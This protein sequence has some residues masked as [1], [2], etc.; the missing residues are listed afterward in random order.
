MA[1][2]HAQ[3]A[4]LEAGL[5]QHVTAP[6]PWIG[7]MTELRRQLRLHSQSIFWLSELQA[8]TRNEPSLSSS[9]SLTPRVSVILPTWNRAEMIMAAIASVCRQAYPHWELLVIDDGSTDATPEVLA[10]ITDPRVRVIRQEHAGCGVARNRGLAE[11]RGDIIAYIDSDNVWYPTYLEEVV[12]AFDAAPDRQ[13]LYLLQLVNNGPEQTTYLRGEPFDR[14]RIRHANWIDLNVFA[15]RRTIAERRG[16]FDPQ[17]HCLI[18]WDFIQRLAQDS[19]PVLIPALGGRYEEGAWKRISNNESQ[20]QAKYQI[21][22]KHEH[23][24]DQPLRVLYLLNSY[25]QI[26]ETYIRTEI[27]YMRR[28]GV[29]VEVCSSFSSLPVAGPAD[30]PVHL[31][32]LPQALI[33]SRPDLVHVHWMCVGLDQLNLIQQAGLPVTYRGHSFEYSTPL[34]ETVLK[35]PAVRRIYLFP[36]MAAHFPA[37]RKIHPLPVAFSPDRFYPPATPKDRRLVVRTGLAKFTKDPLLFLKVAKQCPDHRFV[38]VIATP[39]GL[40]EVPAHIL[41]AK[42]EL[43]SPAEV[44][45]DLSNE[46]AAEVVRS[47]G[48]FLH[49]YSYEEPFGMPISIAEALATGAYVLARQGPDIAGCL[50]PCGALYADA[51]H[52]ARLVTETLS[53]TEDQWQAVALQAVNHAYGHFVDSVVLEAMLDDW[54]VLTAGSTDRGRAA[55]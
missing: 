47:A 17:L 15:H 46:A 32:N 43:N 53:W 23:P 27:E 9:P 13:C 36:H 54:R 11:S 29:H 20:L 55:A 31:G 21:R 51:D 39:R 26:S 10:A 50:G 37:H 4:E 22:R 25:P 6:E 1:H 40:E 42:E 34:A 12:A 3:L 38:L 52:A 16:G 30:V 48:I 14:E 7:P 45:V 44:L 24:I 41:A 19:E 8:Q 33:K 18:D 2:L 35:H 49:T 28:R 5:R